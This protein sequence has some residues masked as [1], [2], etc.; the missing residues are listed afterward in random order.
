MEKKYRENQDLPK[1]QKSNSF[2]FGQL[3]DTAS[4]SKK[5]ITN[6]NKTTEIVSVIDDDVMT[7]EE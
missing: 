7:D 3:D 4:Q 5:Q 1:D 2:Q 6:K